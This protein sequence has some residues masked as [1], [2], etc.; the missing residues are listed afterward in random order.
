M[1]KYVLLFCLFLF[2]ASLTSEAINYF[3]LYN[4]SIIKVE[5]TKL[6]TACFFT[7]CIFVKDH[8]RAPIDTEVHRFAKYT[9]L[10]LLLLQFLAGTIMAMLSSLHTHEPI[11]FVF[12][13][14]YLFTTPALILVLITYLVYYFIAAFILSLVFP[15]CAFLIQKWNSYFSTQK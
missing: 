8:H 14:H 1:K 15:F 12:L 4:I 13:A 5:F 10:S 3:S 9:A 2:A 11:N 6:V 7:A